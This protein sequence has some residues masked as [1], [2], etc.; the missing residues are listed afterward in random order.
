MMQWA[1]L[2]LAILFLIVAY[3]IVQGTRAAM[4]WRKAAA[5]GD[6]KVIRDIVEDALGAWRSVKRPK[7]VR[8]EV[9]RGIQ[10]LQ[11]VDVGADFVRVSCQADS[12]HQL[13]NGRWVEVR[14]PLQEGMAITAQA[15]D[16]LFYELPHFRPERVQIDVYTTY[17]EA[18]GATKRDC[19]LSTATSRETAKLVDWEEWTPEQIVEAL[20]GR[21]RLSDSGRPLP[22]RPAV[23][24]SV[25]TARGNGRRAPASGGP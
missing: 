5:A 2:G 4:A 11:A 14:N 3:I 19:I 10:S 17:G 18:D 15:A 6:V 23:T 1:L 20:G 7:Q 24:A 12:E 13:L 25:R 22:V 21:Y 9:W 16:M 8:T